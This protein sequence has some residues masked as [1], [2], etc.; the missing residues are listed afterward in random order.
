MGLATIP[1]WRVLA[2]WVIGLSL[3][4]LVFRASAARTASVPSLLD[5]ADLFAGPPLSPAGRDSAEVLAFA[6]LVRHVAL[7]ATP[8]EGA[9]PDSLARTLRELRTL[10]RD[11]LWTVQHLPARLSPA[12]HDSLLLGIGAMLAPIAAQASK[13]LAG[14]DAA[15]RRM[16]LEVFAVP[17]TLAVFTVGWFVA[18]RLR[19]RRPSVAAA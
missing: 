17:A 5:R 12:Q 15:I 18:R 2:L 13:P 16:L 10:D 4:I 8:R 19:R 9:P 1:G 7:S 3:E 6:V 14:L 11:S